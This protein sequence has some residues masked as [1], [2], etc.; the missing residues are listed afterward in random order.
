MTGFRVAW[1]GAQVRY[2]I[3][4]D[5]T[6]L[7]KVIGGGLPAGAYAGPKN[8]ME[9]ISP[10]GSVYQAGTLSGN[11]VAMAAGLATLEILKEPGSYS[12]LEQTAADLAAGLTQAAAA[13]NVPLTINRVGSM[14]T[15]FFPQADN[16]P[17]TNFT[18]ATA[19]NPKSFTTFFH[20]MRKS[21]VLLAPSQYEAIFISLAHGKDAIAQTIAAAEDA[22]HA[23]ATAANKN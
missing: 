19:C 3:R 8:L 2:N 9:Q 7:A 18:A 11:P 12:T 15:P 13:A 20:S 23:V 21:G 1:G 17:I 14:L 6:C 4:P 16:T 10:A 5:L 22:L